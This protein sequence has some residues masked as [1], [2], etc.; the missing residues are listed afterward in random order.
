MATAT[1]TPAMTRGQNPRSA[2]AFVNHQGGA[3]HLARVLE[4]LSP[5]DRAVLGVDGSE[6][7]RPVGAD[8]WIPFVVQA[9]LLRAI[10]AVLGRGDLTLLPEVGRFMANRDIPSLFRPL[11]R[12]G[13]T[14]WIITVATRVWR[15][16]HSHG[17][18]DV[19]RAKESVLATL[20]DHPEVDE[21]FCAT[22]LG[23]LEGALEV[24]GGV[25][26]RGEHVVCAARGARNCVFTVS[27]TTTAHRE[28]THVVR[29]R[30]GSSTKP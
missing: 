18:W 15:M 2:L 13:K 1:T 29:A 19:H 8:D 4:R 23:W 20:V 17:A 16:Y 11:L 7:A 22:F 30:S 3:F 10:D 26:V 25:D 24:S 6:G 27:W 28:K 5:D 9:R 12:A 14:G 21:A